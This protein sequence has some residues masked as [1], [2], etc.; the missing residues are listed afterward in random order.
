MTAIARG[1]ELFAL[2]E[3]TCLTLLRTQ[4][5]GRLVVGGEQSHVLPV[6]F[7]VVDRSIVLRT[8]VDGIAARA[9]GGDVLFEVDMLDDRTRS[10]WSVL[11]RGVLVDVDVADAPADVATW[12]PGTHDRCM[13]VT[14]ESISGR[15]LRGAVGG[16]DVEPGG[17]L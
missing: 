2:D 6:N 10:G 8:A 4:P 13:V 14:I 12:A 1:A 9:A 5:V 15:L 17:Y 16:P 7:V 11:A 3:A